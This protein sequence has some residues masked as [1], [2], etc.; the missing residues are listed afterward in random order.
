[1]ER[2][3]H[4]APAGVPLLDTSGTAAPV[5]TRDAQALVERGINAIVTRGIPLVWGARTASTAPEWRYLNVRRL[6]LLLQRSIEEGTRW[7]LLEPDDEP[8]WGRVRA[9]V[10]DFLHGRWRDG[11]LAGGTPED[12]WFVRCDRSTMTQADIDA[13]RLVCLVG[14]APIRPAEFVILRIAQWTAQPRLAAFPFLVAIDDVATAG[15][16][17]VAGLPATPDEGGDHVLRMT[18]GLTI[19]TALADWAARARAGDDASRCGT[20]VL[21]DQDGRAAA[22]WRHHRMRPS[23]LAAASAGGDVVVDLLELV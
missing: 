4:A 17:E 23:A 19:G 3:V 6:V 11:A 18:Q 21:R 15:F 2:G 9:A 16:A 1:M 13:G 5:S 14:I 7:A 8:L 20:V 10:G 22:T 12:A